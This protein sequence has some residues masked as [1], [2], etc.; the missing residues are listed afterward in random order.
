MFWCSRQSCAA[1]VNGCLW[2][3]V[4]RVHSWLCSLFLLFWRTVQIQLLLTW[5]LDCPAVTG[6]C[7]L[8]ERCCGQQMSD[9]IAIAF[10]L[11]SS[12]IFKRWNPW[13]LNV[14]ALTRS[15]PTPPSDRRFSDP[16]DSTWQQW[17]LVF[18]FPP[19]AV[20]SGRDYVWWKLG[21][22]TKLIRQSMF[23]QIPSLLH[24][25]SWQKQYASRAFEGGDFDSPG[26]E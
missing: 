4:Q 12:R 2:G 1:G 21:F 11:F 8:F 15:V 6:I 26:H 22:R 3:S 7:Y 10:N 20:S 18:F 14:I 24:G 9:K 17:D 23:L 13:P 16:C 19:S 25:G 5:D